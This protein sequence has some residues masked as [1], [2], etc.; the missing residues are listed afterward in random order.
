MLTDFYNLTPEQ[1]AQLCPTHDP[2]DYNPPG[3]SVHGVFQ[4]RVLEWAAISFYNFLSFS[5]WNNYNFSSAVSGALW[6][7]INSAVELYAPTTSAEEAEVEW[8]CEDLQDLL[9]LTPKK[10]V[11]FLIRD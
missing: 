5:F 11:L 9:E 4:A 6:K 10:Y 3:F 2:M 7:N 8:L 1:L